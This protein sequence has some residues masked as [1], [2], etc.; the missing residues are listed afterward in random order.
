MSQVDRFL[1]FSAIL[2][3]V[4]LV[5]T[6]VYAIKWI[7]ALFSFLSA[8]NG[9]QATRIGSDHAIG[10]VQSN[11]QRLAKKIYS[12]NSYH[13]GEIT[14]SYVMLWSP[15]VH[16]LQL[17]PNTEASIHTLLRDLSANSFEVSQVASAYRVNGFDSARTGL[18]S[19][20]PS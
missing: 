7:E 3:K 11:V 10:D 6:C 18:P 12:R 8:Y 5:P 17:S 14:N 13:L 16:S 15:S 2:R 19:P 20:I 4:R 9:A 1:L